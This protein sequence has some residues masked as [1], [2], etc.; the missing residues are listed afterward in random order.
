MAPRPAV[1]A[2]PWLASLA[3]LTVVGLAALL[4]W[5]SRGNLNADGVSYLDLAERLRAGDLA[6]FV[7]GYWSPAYPLLLGAL[8]T[9]TGA[10]GHEAAV[11]AHLLNFVMAAAAAGL[12]W[13]AGRERSPTWT[14]LLLTALLVSS[15]RTIR[16]DAV[17]PDLL[18]LLLVTGFG[19]ELVRA[20]GWRGPVLGAWAGAAFLAKTSSWPWL[21]ASTVLVTWHAWQPADRRR[22]VLA[23]V[24]VAL[25]PVMSWVVAMSIDA[26]H[27][28]L[29]SAARL[30]ACWYLRLCDGRSPDSHEGDHEAYAT[31]PVREGA[32]ARVARFDQPHWTYQPWSDPTAWQAGISDQRDEPITAGRYLAFVVRQAGPVL[33]I[34]CPLVVLLVLAPAIGLH[35]AAPRPS[36]ARPPPAA[37]L[38]V[39]LGVLGVLQFVA[40]HAEPRLIAPFLTLAS[41]GVVTWAHGGTAR[42][43][44]APVV[45][46]AFAVALAIGAWHVPEQ[47]RITASSADRVRQLE[48][49]LPPGSAPHRVAVLNDAF[50]MLP[51]LYRA[52]ARVVV[53]VMAPDVTEL[54][55]WPAT[56]GQALLDRLKAAGAETLWLSR[57]RDGYSIVRLRP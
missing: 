44:L 15:A 40:V 22:Q 5:A 55:R 53:Q 37:G 14:L 25:V 8:L 38:A 27:P 26:G 56:A 43:A 45:G 23:A 34:W 4:A 19:T 24:A 50:P 51:D 2:A 10:S 29:G 30:N 36:L 39:V 33:G 6:A 20:G 7:Q 47:L 28:T 3:T 21:L 18:L 35:R 12:I 32:V 54:A 46:V 1:G 48:V 16:V 57:A 11:Q 49:Q 52:R 42:P 17:T 9:L 13:R 31:W 41:I